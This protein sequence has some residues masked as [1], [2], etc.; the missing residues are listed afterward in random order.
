M[1]FRSTASWVLLAAMLTPATP[2]FS[3]I[4]YQTAP[5]AE[6]KKTLMLRDF[7]PRTMMHAAVHPVE[8]AKFPVVDVHQHVDD[9]MGIG[10][11][12]PP[13]RLVEIMDQ[14]NVN[15]DDHSDRYV[16]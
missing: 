4:T 11:R 10:D 7:H 9:A 8:R 16:G 15:E 1:N 14:T 12:I 3:Q 2:L 6:Q 5:D 13:A